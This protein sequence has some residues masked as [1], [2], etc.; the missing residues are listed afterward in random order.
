MGVLERTAVGGVGVHL[1]VVGCI[2]ELAYERRWFALREPHRQDGL[3]V[4]ST[5]PISDVILDFFVLN[6]R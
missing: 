6:Y 1:P 2:E 3:T 5:F 4:R